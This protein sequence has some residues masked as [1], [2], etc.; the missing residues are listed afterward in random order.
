LFFDTKRAIASSDFSFYWLVG[1]YYRAHLHIKK[2][3][4]KGESDIVSGIQSIR[5]AYD[6][7]Q[8]FVRERPGSLAERMFGGYCKRLEWIANDLLSCPHFPDLVRDGIRKEWQSDN[9]SVPAISEK[10][11]LLPVDQR[12]IV[13][14]IIDQLISGKQ[15][16]ITIETKE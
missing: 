1:I 6:H 12:A 16:E 13:E 8:S 2:H 15:L 3:T 10:V 9:F 7:W 4:M 14:D 5:R 11:A